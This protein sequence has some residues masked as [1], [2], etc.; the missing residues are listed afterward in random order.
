MGLILLFTLAGAILGDIIFG[1][2]IIF[3]GS[4]FGFMVGLVFAVVIGSF[5]PQKDVLSEVV[6]PLAFQTVTFEKRFFRTNGYEY[7]FYYQDGNK[8]KFRT[9]PINLVSIIEEA[10]RTDSLI[11]VYYKCFTKE[12]YFAW[13]IPSIHRKYEL[14]IPSGSIVCG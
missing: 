14:Y 2:I 10:D 11:K 4:F 6:W 12:C 9:I 7:L 8:I 13:G 1:G 5:L 3:V